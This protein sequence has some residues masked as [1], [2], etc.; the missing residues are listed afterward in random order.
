MTELERLAELIESA[1]YWG[2]DTPKEIARFIIANGATYPPCKLGDTVYRIVEMG[3]GIHY[4]Q[5]GRY[6][7]GCSKGYK[8]APCKE[9]IKRFIRPVRV[10]KSN[11]FDICENIGKTVF[12]TREEAEDALAERSKT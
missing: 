7:V 11:F 12:L 4:K 8:I 6:E 10:T 3:T 1:M 2:A 9:T 5:V